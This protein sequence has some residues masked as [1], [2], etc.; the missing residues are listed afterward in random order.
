VKSKQSAEFEISGKEIGYNEFMQV[1]D[2][3][4]AAGTDCTITI[5]QLSYDERPYGNY[6]RTDI[7][8]EA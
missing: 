7:T 1:Y 8:V 2:A 3:V 4:I 6:T 5:D